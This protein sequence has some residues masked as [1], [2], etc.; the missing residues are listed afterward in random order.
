MKLK[1]L[2]LNSLISHELNDDEMEYV[3][4]RA[5]ISVCLEGNSCA[6]I[7]EGWESVYEDKAD[8]CIEWVKDNEPLLPSTR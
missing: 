7:C 3:K 8:S 2:S 4:G 6:D 1:R 5:G